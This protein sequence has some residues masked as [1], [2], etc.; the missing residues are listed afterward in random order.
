MDLT[1]LTQLELLELNGRIEIELKEYDKRD[2]TKVFRIM[3]FGSATYFSTAKKAEE[4]L[5]HLIEEY[6]F[7]EM[8]TDESLIISVDYMNDSDFKQWVRD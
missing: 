8:L 5:Y 2:Q 7:E 6:D 3:A 4:H 1:K